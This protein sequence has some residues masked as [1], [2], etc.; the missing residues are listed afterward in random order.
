MPKIGLGLQVCTV[1]G[2]NY[3]STF[4]VQ[5]LV[6][7]GLENIHCFY[8]KYLYILL[9]YI[10]FTLNNCQSK[11]WSSVAYRHT[12]VF[13]LKRL[14]FFTRPLCKI[15]EVVSLNYLPG[16]KNTLHLPNIHVH[17][18]YTLKI[19]MFSKVI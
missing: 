8:K 9:Q 7:R 18:M 1:S 5:L 10:A 13:S 19:L 17:S 14:M 2:L 6:L 12:N 4:E 3:F 11:F 16:H 15:N